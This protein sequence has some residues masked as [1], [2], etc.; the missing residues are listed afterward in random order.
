MT[1]EQAITAST[2]L[3]KRAEVERNQ[4]AYERE[5]EN[6]ANA[7]E[8]ERLAETYEAV[9]DFLHDWGR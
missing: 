1:Y 3:R 4:A 7:K 9:A 8:M 6:H 5:W 2:L